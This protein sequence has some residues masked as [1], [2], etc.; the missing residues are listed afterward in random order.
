MWNHVKVKYI[1]IFYILETTFPKIPEKLRTFFLDLF[2]LWPK[3]LYK[4]CK[5]KKSFIRLL[6][7]MRAWNAYYSAIKGEGK[8]KIHSNMNIYIY[9]HIHKNFPVWYCR[10][11]RRESSPFLSLVGCTVVFFRLYWFSVQIVPLDDYS[12]ERKQFRYI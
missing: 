9:I 3:H 8:L 10:I 1:Y 11:I 12:A 5:R 6:K 4:F 7:C 2:G